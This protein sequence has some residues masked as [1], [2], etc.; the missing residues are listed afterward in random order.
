MKDKGFTLV[1]LMV[2]ISISGII[3]LAVSAIIGTLFSSSARVTQIDTL[4]QLK[5]DI[6]KDISTSVR[7]ASSVVVSP[8]NDELT[9]TSTQGD[10]TVYRL[11]DNELL[12]NDIR[13]HPADHEVTAFS[14]HDYG[15]GK[16]ASL[17][18]E[19]ALRSKK[20]T[21]RSDTIT[22]VISQRQTEVTINQ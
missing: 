6:S 13:L 21:A 17:E 7:W 18:I 1:E 3:F 5:D 9:L 19:I 14:V 16:K 22:V 12:K 8:G 4:A 11:V 2:A 20:F 15:A 10:T